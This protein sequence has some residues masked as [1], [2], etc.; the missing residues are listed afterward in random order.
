MKIIFYLSSIVFLF[1]ELQW[2]IAP[3][4]EAEK[5]KRRELLVKQTK[6]VKFD[7]LTSQQKSDYITIIILFIFC[8]GW[9]FV[10]LFT[11]QWQVFLAFLLLQIIVISPIS[12]LTKYSFFYTA[13][14]WLN[15]IFGLAFILFVIINSYH[16]KIDIDFIKYIR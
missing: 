11:F 15:S 16:L 10:G 5:S 4:Q 7:L 3:S 8:F 9:L 12:K 6:N 1:K 2:I 14:H 13:L